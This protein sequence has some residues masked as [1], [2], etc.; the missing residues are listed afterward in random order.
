P[1]VLLVGL[2]REAEN[3]QQSVGGL[4]VRDFDLNLPYT[5]D[6]IGNDL[7]D[8]ERDL[9]ARVP[10]TDP[11]RGV[12]PHDV[13]DVAAHETVSHVLT[14][15]REDSPRDVVGVDVQDL[16]L[17]FGAYEHGPW[18][19]AGWVASATSRAS[20]KCLRHLRHGPTLTRIRGRT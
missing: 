17:E 4:E 6:L 9:R 3:R 5:I 20:A 18:P 15:R 8:A 1:T 12:S 7:L 10:Q 11:S 19:P 14:A 2:G 13:V 16:G